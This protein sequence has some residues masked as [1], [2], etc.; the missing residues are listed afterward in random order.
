MFTVEN[1]AVKKN[2]KKKNNP[3][4]LNIDC[5]SE[6]GFG[7]QRGEVLKVLSEA[8]ELVED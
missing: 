4:L 5:Y 8:M 2:R 1:V 3:N 6:L 7:M